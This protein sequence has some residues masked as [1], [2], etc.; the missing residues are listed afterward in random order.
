MSRW[1]TPCE[2]ACERADAVS[3][4]RWARAALAEGHCRRRRG[5]AFA[6][7]EFHGDEMNPLEDAG[8]E[9]AGQVRIVDLLRQLHFALEASEQ[10]LLGPGDFG[11]QNLEGDVPAVAGI[12]RQIDGPH[13]AAA[14]RDEDAVRPE[15]QA[16]RDALLELVDLEA[17]QL[18]G[19][20]EMLNDGGHVLAP[21]LRQAAQGILQL[22]AV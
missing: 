21:L 11:R 6:R 12:D 8:F 15:D 17:R 10:P 4:I 19:G 18:A 1:M 5:R 2:W 20:D 22:L 9:R 14:E 3:A 16:E 13:A 7:D